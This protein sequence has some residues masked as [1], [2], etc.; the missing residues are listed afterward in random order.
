MDLFI[1]AFIIFS[2][3]VADQSLG[4]MRARLVSRNKPIYGA[5]IGLVES[6]IWIVA[7]SQVINDIDKPILNLLHL[8]PLECNQRHNHDLKRHKWVLL[9]VQLHLTLVLLMGVLVSSRYFSL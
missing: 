9:R 1:S 6:A 5:L 4:T 2:L 7:V 8:L 3:R